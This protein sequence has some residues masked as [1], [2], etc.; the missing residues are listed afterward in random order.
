M[1]AK[2]SIEAPIYYENY[3]HFSYLGLPRISFFYMVATPRKNS[4][5]APGEYF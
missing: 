3:M 4:S 2:F 5:S 1:A